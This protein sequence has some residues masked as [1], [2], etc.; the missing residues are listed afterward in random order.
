MKIESKP[1]K[2]TYTFIL[3]MDDRDVEDMMTVLEE[4]KGR[5]QDHLTEP[6]VDT[7]H[8]FWE[9]LYEAHCVRDD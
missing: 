4:V 2:K 1:P 5:L 9:A 6:Q 3:Q 7:A 8:A